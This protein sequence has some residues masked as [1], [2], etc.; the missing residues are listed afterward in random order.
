MVINRAEF[1]AVFGEPD[2]LALFASL[3]LDRLVHTTGESHII[4]HNRII[5]TY[6]LLY[7]PCM[8]PAWAPPRGVVKGAEPPLHRAEAGERQPPGGMAS[9]PPLRS[10]LPPSPPIS[11]HLLPSPPFHH[12]PI[13]G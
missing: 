1:E 11:P 12:P 6:G 4:A 3:D 13:V 10:S 5:G 7:G 2:L 9:L 8:P